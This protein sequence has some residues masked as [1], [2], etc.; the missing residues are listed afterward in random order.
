MV[1]NTRSIAKFHH[2]FNLADEAITKSFQFILHPSG[3]EPVGSV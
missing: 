1:F 3:K 2:P